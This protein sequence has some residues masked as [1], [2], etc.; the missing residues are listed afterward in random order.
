MKLTIQPGGVLVSIFFGCLAAAIFHLSA[1]WCVVI[2]LGT[3]PALSFALWLLLKL[4]DTPPV[5]ALDRYLSQRKRAKKVAA[6][7]KRMR[8]RESR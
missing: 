1:V 3:V 4:L 8:A 2:G 6:A 5:D 7:K